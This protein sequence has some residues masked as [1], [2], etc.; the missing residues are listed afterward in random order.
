MF[1]DEMSAQDGPSLD[2]MAADVL[3]KGRRVKR[4]RSVKIASTVLMA[5][6]LGAAAVMVPT[7]VGSHPGGAV[8]KSAS[9]AGTHTQTAPAGGESAAPIGSANPVPGSSGQLILTDVNTPEHISQ[10]PGPKAPT[11]SAA[12]LDELLKLLPPGATSNYALYDLGA[13]TYLNGP[14]G[15]GM[16][17]VFLYHGSINPDVCTGSHRDMTQTCSTL[18]SGAKVVTTKI[19]DNCIEPLAI[20][21]DHGDG[22][23]VQIDPSTCLAWNGQSNPPSPMAITPE[24]A[25]Q[26][27]ENPAWGAVQMDASVV[28]DGASRFADIPAGS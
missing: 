8:A 28:S 13:Q 12:I 20:A 27:A 25:L 6:A 19:S 4:A 11:T 17:R 10:T 24:Q 23:V 26:I 7:I 9:P 21:V 18:P 2:G 22:T 16:I 14:S 15:L 5:G 3:S 1:R